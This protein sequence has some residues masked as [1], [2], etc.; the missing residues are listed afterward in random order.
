MKPLI[1]YLACPYQHED[2][3]IKAL[4]LD[5]VTEVAALFH[6]KGH[7]V[8]SPLTHNYPLCQ[9]GVTQTWDTWRQFDLGLLERC[10]KLLVLSLP[11]WEISKGVQAEIEHAKDLK[12]PIEFLQ[13]CLNK[14]Q[15]LHSF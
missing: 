3:N 9:K 5:I 4:R 7:F 12:I 2:P 11:G 1:A 10:D 6:C 8:Y 15:L 13:Y 14:R